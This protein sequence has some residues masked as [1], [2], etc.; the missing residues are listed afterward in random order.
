METEQWTLE[1]IRD[2]RAGTEFNVSDG[3]QPYGQSIHYTHIFLSS[4]MTC[5]VTFQPV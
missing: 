2:L 5:V 4:S 3:T 1:R